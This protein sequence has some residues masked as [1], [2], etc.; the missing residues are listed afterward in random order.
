ML[1]RHICVPRRPGNVQ[2]AYIAHAVQG[3]PTRGCNKASRGDCVLLRNRLRTT[4]NDATD[5]CRWVD[6]RS[7]PHAQYCLCRA[8]FIGI[9]SHGICGVPVTGI[10]SRALPPR[11][12][13]TW[14]EGWRALKVLLPKR[15][16][17]YRGGG[18]SYDEDGSRGGVVPADH[19]SPEAVLPSGPR[20][21]STDAIVAPTPQSHLRATHAA[22]FL[23]G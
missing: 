4:T 23:E 19:S 21:V 20:P 5:F 16:T 12:H 14:E 7:A 17:H 10:G 8:A 9:L 2:T 13:R 1:G 15:C 22:D 11:G 18:W 3:V 6:V